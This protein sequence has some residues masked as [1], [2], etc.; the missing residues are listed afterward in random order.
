MSEKMAIRER[1]RERE[2]ERALDEQEEKW[3]II[4]NRGRT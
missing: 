2:R 4:I 1:E 3:G